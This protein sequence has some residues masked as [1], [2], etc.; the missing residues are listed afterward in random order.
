MM[1]ILTSSNRPALRLVHDCEHEGAWAWFCGHCSAPAPGDDPP[2]PAARVCQECGLGLLL[3]TRADSVPSPDDAFLVIDDSLRVQALS[4]HAESLLAV[5]E[6][7]AVNQPVAGLLVPADAEGS[8]PGRFANAVARALGD[9]DPA[10]IFVRPWNTFGVRLRAR[11]SP[12]GPPRAAL[13]V[14][15][16]P[17]PRLRVV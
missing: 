10:Q 3:E 11:I 17:P 5:S 2:A 13:V 8:E 6:E 4:R 12:C 7:A 14:L 15:E 16:T 1:G 9:E